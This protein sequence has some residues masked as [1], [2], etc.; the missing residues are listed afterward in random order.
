MRSLLMLVAMNLAF[1]AACGK[2]TG[3]ESVIV[4]DSPIICEEEGNS[5]EFKQCMRQPD[6]VTSSEY[7]RNDGEI[8]DTSPTAGETVLGIVL[9]PFEILSALPL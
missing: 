5:E 8:P 6:A 4:E 7:F 3:D 2:N 1:L 9:L